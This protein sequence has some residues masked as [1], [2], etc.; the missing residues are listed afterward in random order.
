MLELKQ[1]TSS[2]GI[3]RRVPYLGKS[4]ICLQSACSSN[5]TIT[6]MPPPATWTR[7]NFTNRYSERQIRTKHHMHHTPDR[8]LS[9][10]HPEGAL[11]R[12]WPAQI[13][14]VLT[15]VHRAHIK[16]IK[17]MTEEPKCCCREKS[18][19]LCPRSPLLVASLFLLLLRFNDEDTLHPYQATRS[20]IL[21]S[22]A[23]TGKHQD[24]R[25]CCFR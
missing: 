2:R 10:F 12:L 9:V 14:P 23:P 4:T 20:N 19:Q 13:Q 7:I 17:L 25:D 15:V 3:V 11:N 1:S 18:L 16:R 8:T 21:G 22:T 24:N 5:S 6:L